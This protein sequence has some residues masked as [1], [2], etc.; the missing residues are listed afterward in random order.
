[1]KSATP[2]ISTAPTF[3]YLPT[4]DEGTT[5]DLYVDAAS[6]SDSN[7]GLTP[8]SAKQTIGAA[9]AAAMAGSEIKVRAGTYRERVDFTGKGGSLGNRTTVSAYGTER[10]VIT[11]ASAITGWTAC[12]VA[13]QPVVGP[14]YASIYKKTVLKSLF[15][16]SDPRSAHP[17]EAG[18]KLSPAI[19]WKPNPQ[20]PNSEQA[21]SQWWTADLTVT[22]AHKLNYTALTGAFTVGQVVTG[23]DSGATATITADDGSTLTI[24]GLSG[25]FDPAEAITDPLGGAATTNGNEYVAILGYQDASVTSLY[26][27][28]QIENADVFF[29]RF[30][31]TNARTKV[32]SFDTG[33]GT[34]YLTDQKGEYENNSYK[35][36]YMLINLLPAIRQGQWGF[37]DD[38]A[39]DCTLYVWPSNPANMTSGIEITERGACITADT[40]SHIEIR[41][42]ILERASAHPGG[43]SSDGNYAFNA[44]GVSKRSNVVIDNCLIRD[45]YRS[46]RDYAPIWIGNVD[47][48]RILNTTVQDAYNQF[49]I[50]CQG[51]AWDSGGM[52]TGGWADRVLIQRV[53]NSPFRIYGNTKGAV[54]NSL[55]RNA[56]VA[57]HAN[58]GNNY[59]DCHQFLWLNWDTRGCS[60]YQTWQRASSIALVNCDIPVS[61]GG[62]DGRAIVD[63][64]STGTNL[65]PATEQ[66]INGDSYIL[67][68]ITEPY[69]EA[70]AAART[71]ALT[72][73]Q[74]L[75]TAVLYTVKNCVLHGASTVNPALLKA[76]G[77]KNNVL[78]AGSTLD[79]SD[80]TATIASVYA[81]YVTGDTSVLP[82]SPTVALPGA[83]VSAE[84]A[85]IKSWVPQVPATHFDTDAYGN[86]VT[87][88]AP[89]VGPFQDVS[90]A[91]TVDPIW[92][93]RPTIS[94]TPTVGSSLTGD[95]GYRVAFP[96]LPVTYQW[97][98]SSDL[99]T[100]TDIP[101]ATGASYTLTSGETG[102]YVGRATICG[103]AEAF[104]YVGTAVSASYPL[105]NPAAAQVRFAS[106]GGTQHETPTFTVENRPMV[107]LVANRLSTAANSPQTLTIGTPGRAYG[108][109]TAIPQVGLHRRGSIQITAHYIA[110]PGTGSVTIQQEGAENTAYVVAAYYVDGA[111][112]ITAGSNN[113]GTTTVVNPS[114]TTTAANSIAI[115]MAIKS[116]ANTGTGWTTSGATQ[117][118]MNKTDT[119]SDG[120]WVVTAYETAPTAGATATATF[121]SDVSGTVIGAVF[122]I[123]S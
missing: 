106:D 107:V 81:D 77:W 105:G 114:T 15:V 16:G 9:M 43:T 113:Q 62:S 120:I 116:G 117:L 21:T 14:N 75:D 24:S 121:T 40:V 93:N 59:S 56:G 61:F 88:T 46:E 89:G 94:G 66:G 30:P 54:T 28:A 103:S 118:D 48:W 55:A 70:V 27:Q 73:A 4:R 31:N 111:T 37:T 100:W 3:G 2:T 12:T 87:W 65:S 95:A 44:G 17:Y 13:D 25:T 123:L 11:A 39:T 91:P 109:G 8:A 86:A 34:I 38:N 119:L 110:A 20:Y 32:A 96:F 60:G 79:A 18:V 22:V 104:G 72:I 42:L 36:N 29:H 69:V 97:R 10:P 53:D 50:F 26:T 108:T 102:L 68:C 45:T 122:E 98:T 41:G 112:G 6:G 92:I 101:G 19:S 35:D 74:V 80:T 67:N 51:Q 99:M 5:G 115:Y 1:M 33:T 23:A 84:I 83:D 64:N 82:G 78:T 49:G 90:Q 57:A 7:D 47:D 58:K 76:N 63:Q 71:N 52:A 85:I